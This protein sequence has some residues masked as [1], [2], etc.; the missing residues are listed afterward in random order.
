MLVRVLRE[1]KEP[2][3]PPADTVLSQG[4]FLHL[5]TGQFAV[6]AAE[7]GFDAVAVWRQAP[8]YGG[9]HKTARAVAEAGV[10]V[11]TLCRGGVLS[12]A[13]HDDTVRALDEAATLGATQLVVIAGPPQPGNMP[14]AEADLADA[15]ELALPIAEQTGVVL[16]LEPFHP[17]LAGDRSWLVTLA[18]AAGIAERFDSPSLGIAV[19]SYHLWWEPRLAAGL[20]R[21]GH[22]ITAVQIADWI[23][24]S[25][26][27]LPPRGIP[28]EGVIPLGRFLRLTR[29]AGYPGPVEIEVLGDRFRSLPPLEAARTLKTALDD[30]AVGAEEGSHA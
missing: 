17:M 19:D 8:G 27:H 5:D 21:V 14:A 11:E 3:M 13:G 4:S 18:Q 1:T 6:A 16:A 23:V 24:P 26:G 9:A 20:A 28:G 7:A 2:A 12:R 15:M 30:V 22:R 25:S 29:A 10:R